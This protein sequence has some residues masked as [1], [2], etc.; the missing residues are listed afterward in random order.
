LKTS[1]VS[2]FALLARSRGALTK[3]LRLRVS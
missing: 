1:T 2:R 3:R